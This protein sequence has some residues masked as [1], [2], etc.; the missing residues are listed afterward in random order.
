MK[1]LAF[2]QNVLDILLTASHLQRHGH[3]VSMANTGRKKS[4]CVSL[5]NSESV[6]SLN[7]GQE[8]YFFALVPSFYS[9]YL[10]TNDE[11][12]R[13]QSG[14]GIL[15]RTAHCWCEKQTKPLLVCV[16]VWGVYV[17][18]NVCANVWVF[19]CVHVETWVNTGNFPAYS[20]S[21]SLRQSLS[22]EP[23]THW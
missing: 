7:G 15:T 9:H 10:L 8:I 2:P 21:Y 16:C 14:R 18:V 23:S 17:W 4:R 20:P 12:G 6:F 22:V 1:H 3:Y 5:S 11:M 19:V 13:V